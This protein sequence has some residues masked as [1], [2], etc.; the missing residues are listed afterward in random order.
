MQENKTDKFPI[1]ST[2]IG[3]VVGKTETFS[4][5]EKIE[6]NSFKRKLQTDE[7]EIIGSNIGKRKKLNADQDTSKVINKSIPNLCSM[8]TPEIRLIKFDYVQPNKN[9]KITIEKMPQL[10]VKEKK[11]ISYISQDVFPLFISLCLQKCPKHDKNDMDKIVDKLKRYY[12]NMDPTY[13]SS[14]DFVI[15]LNQKR[16]AIMNNSKKIYIYMEEVKNE[17]KKKIKKKFQV[18]QNNEIY[19]A[20]P[21]T[22]YATNNVSVNE[23]ELNNDDGDYDDDDD[24]EEDARLKREEEYST[25][26]KIKQ[27]LHTMKKCEANIKRLEEEEVDFD[28]EN[29]SN[30]I[31][32]ERYKRRMIELYNKLCELTGENA[33][34][35]R[36]YLRPKHLNV[37]RI[38]AVDQAITNF[39]NSKITRRN[40]MKQ[41]GVLTDDLIFPDY[42]DILECVNRC[43]D[44]KNLGLD[45]RRREKM[46]KLHIVLN[47]FMSIFYLYN[48]FCCTFNP[49]PHNNTSDTRITDYI[50]NMINTNMT[51]K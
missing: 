1:K 27:I 12:E 23:E 29:D 30:Y 9:Q 19:D 37:T 50:L 36:V 45:K 48:S 4:D 10:I 33:D 11:K 31:K 20:V 35:G 2:N 22:S 5:N 25:K 13:T 6:E 16:E 32:V 3:G 26:R 7:D 21:S 24:N 47:L 43:N 8:Y 17:M 41:T 18:L 49:L 51:H 44:K 38:V 14:E 34:A 28:D 15:F 46:G 42:R 39:I 40:Q